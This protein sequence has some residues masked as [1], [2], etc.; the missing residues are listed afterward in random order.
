MGWGDETG[1]TSMTGAKPD[2]G[3]RS[4]SL[5]APIL[6]V[7]YSLILAAPLAIAW[8]SGMQPFSS[9]WEATSATGLVGLTML[10][11]QFVTSGRYE[12]MSGRV[13]IDVT[14]A[15][16]KWAARILLVVVIA[17]PLLPHFPFSFDQMGAFF[18][19]VGAM[20]VRPRYLSG[21]VA[22]G[23]V[24]IIVVLALLRNRLPIP[25]EIWRA[26]HGLMVLA[27]VW[28]VAMHAIGVGTYS[29]DGLLRLLWPALAVVA[30]A[31]LLGV[32]LIKTYRMRHL[33]WRVVSNRKAANRLW[34]VKISPEGSHRL[35]F[36]AGQFAWITFAPRRLLLLD[37]PFSIASSPLGGE[38]L[39]FLIKE[40]GDFTR[41]IGEIEPGR[42]VG[43]DAPH[44][45]FT[46]AD[47]DADAV[48]LIAGGVGVAPIMGLLRDLQ[49]RADK[50]PVRLIYAAGSPASMIDPK[51][52]LAEAPDLDLKAQ[53]VVEQP[54][55]HWPY[56]TGLVDDNVLTVAFDGLD[57]G[58]IAVMMCGPPAMTAALADKVQGKGV[59][60]H[61]I[62]YERFDYSGGHRSRKDWLIT[63][64][65]WAMAVSV[66]AVGTLF[67]LR[68]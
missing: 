52:I 61:L 9:W 53:F 13:G 28:I 67:A 36:T 50:R 11:L 6:A 65:F 37:H 44:G 14:M 26:S 51:A 46:L 25:H 48:V 66:L 32:H 33:P 57:P 56:Q 12:T 21:T 24:I 15:F 60:L 43:L 19:D 5:S 23:F 38:T 22:L 55:D 39:T 16:H 35:H 30:T 17:H 63:A 59:P 42:L 62:H 45:S 7:A 4:S 29:R 40:L 41:H 10:M 31:L 18:G 68:G 58:R 27:T 20:M 54:D 1:P 64:S 47:R 49:A 8:V 3:E 2:R 34:E